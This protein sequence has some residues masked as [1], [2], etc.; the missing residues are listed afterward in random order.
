MS[1]VN[2]RGLHQGYSKVDTLA[3]SLKEVLL[4]TAEEVLGIQSKKIQPLITNKVLDLC[5]QRWQL[6]R[7]K[8]TSTEAG[9]DYRK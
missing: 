2:H 8:Y 5:D 3:K 1:P 7:Q 4:L 6:K 9:L